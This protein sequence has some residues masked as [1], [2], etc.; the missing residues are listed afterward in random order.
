MTTTPA[1]PPF[2]ALP[3]TQPGTVLHTTANDTHALLTGG[4]AGQAYLPS[5]P[6]GRCLQPGTLDRF[7]LAAPG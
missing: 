5:A 3:L 6:S 1:V 2:L 4:E 7:G